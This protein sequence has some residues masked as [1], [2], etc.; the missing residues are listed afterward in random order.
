M[1][2]PNM[3]YTEGAAKREVVALRGINYGDSLQDGDLVSCENLS[4]RRYPYL[5]TRRPRARQTAQ[6]GPTTTALT[7]WGK[8]VA[9]QGTELTYDGKKVGE[10]TAGEKQFAVVNTKLGIWPDK[11]YLEPEREAPGRKSPGDRRELHGQRPERGLGDGPDHALPGGGLRDHLRLHGG[12][13]EQPGRGADG[14]GGEEAYG[15]QEH[16][17]GQ[18][19]D[20]D[21]DH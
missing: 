12:E 6:S 19:G 4:A 8:L 15:G 10:V 21:A 14:S 5:S 18:G 20:G 11:V 9:V 16:L 3:R 7:A 1:K 13:G 2:L 17:Y